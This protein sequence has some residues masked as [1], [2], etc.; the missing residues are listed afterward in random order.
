MDTPTP[1]R[2]L[3]VA[4]GLA[5]LSLDVMASVAYGPESIGLVL[6][7]AGS[8]G[9]GVP[10]PVTVA[11]VLLVLVMERIRKQYNRI[12]GCRGTGWVP[13][14]LSLGH[15]LVAVHVCLPRENTT[16]FTKAWEA[17]HPEVHPEIIDAGDCGV[18]APVARYVRENFDGRRKVVLI[19]EVDPPAG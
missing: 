7:A 13:A 19:A 9:L 17:W 10:L 3:T 6:A 1:R 16:A 15:D 4:T 18:G 12:D 11:I 14:A 5:G 2:G 8:A